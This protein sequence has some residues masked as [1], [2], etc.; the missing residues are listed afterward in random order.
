MFLISRHCSCCKDLSFVSYSSL[1]HMILHVV[2][3]Q[4]N[5]LIDKMAAIIT[6]IMSKHNHALT[7]EIHHLYS[8]IKSGKYSFAFG[9]GSKDIC[10]GLSPPKAPDV[11]LINKSW[12]RR[13]GLA[14]VHS[15]PFSLM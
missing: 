8:L 14:R 3:Q 7:S 1:L 6:A 10:V 2:S 9:G 12:K 13:L 11:P 4:H 15:L 5:S